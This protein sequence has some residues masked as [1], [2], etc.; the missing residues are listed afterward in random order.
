MRGATSTFSEHIGRAA[1][2]DK[3]GNRRRL[4]LVVAAFGQPDQPPVRTPAV[5]AR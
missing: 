5:R 3:G 1:A 4:L 2:T